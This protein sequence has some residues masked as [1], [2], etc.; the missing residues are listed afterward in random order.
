M[1]ILE[2]LIDVALKCCEKSRLSGLKFHHAR[3]CALL[4]SSGKVISHISPSCF[5]IPH[6]GLQRMRCI[7]FQNDVDRFSWNITRFSLSGCYCRKGRDIGGNFRW[8]QRF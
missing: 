6:P 5:S 1:T 2:E 4:T 3:G 8:I 7:C